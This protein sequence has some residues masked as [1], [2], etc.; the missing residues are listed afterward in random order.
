MRTGILGSA[1]AGDPAVMR[2]T[3]AVSRN[4]AS[5]D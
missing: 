1:V 4:P 3:V 2:P 5:R